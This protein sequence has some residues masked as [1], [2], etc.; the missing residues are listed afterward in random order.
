VERYKFSLL[1][2]EPLYTNVLTLRQTL[3]S[4]FPG[5]IRGFQNNFT[6]KITVLDF[7]G[8]SLTEHLCFLDGLPANH[9]P[10]KVEYSDAFINPLKGFVGLNFTPTDELLAYRQNLIDTA[11]ACGL[12]ISDQ[13]REFRPHVTLGRIKARGRREH[14]NSYQKRIDEVFNSLS[15]LANSTALTGTLRPGFLRQVVGDNT[16]VRY[17][18]RDSLSDITRPDNDAVNG[19]PHVVQVDGRMPLRDMLFG[20]PDNPLEY[21]I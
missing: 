7:K 18:F 1:P 12:T 13:D 8:G 4:E 19:C 5:Q 2:D 3:K 17:L 9:Y 6:P 14:K 20:T 10:V 16:N 11:I 21:V 15:S